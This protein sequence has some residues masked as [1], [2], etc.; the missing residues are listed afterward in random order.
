MWS[1]PLQTLVVIDVRPDVAGLPTKAYVA[2]EEVHD[3]STHSH[4]L[5]ESQRLELGCYT[6]AWCWLS[7]PCVQLIV[8]LLQDGTPT[9]KTFEHVSSQVGA[10]EVEEVR[11]ARRVQCVALETPLF[12]GP[13][14]IDEVL[15]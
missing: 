15:S 2:V 8:R 7:E 5:T 9:S 3:V 10:E 12:W 14:R 1:P 11:D 6:S 13:S 4:H